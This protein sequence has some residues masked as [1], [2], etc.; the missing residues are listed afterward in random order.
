MVLYTKRHCDCH[1]T[2]DN[3]KKI[4]FGDQLIMVLINFL[5]KSEAC[6]KNNENLPTRIKNGNTLN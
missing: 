6:L 3:D 5:I 2:I 4:F 1:A